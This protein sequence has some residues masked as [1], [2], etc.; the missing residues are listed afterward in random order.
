MSYSLLRRSC[1]LFGLLSCTLTSA[2]SQSFE[3]ALS[4]AD[5][6]EHA[7]DQQP[8]LFGEWGGERTKLMDEGVKFGLM[9]SSDS[10]W[11]IRSA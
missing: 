5:Q 8:H 10:L 1:F 7:A 6:S 2:W 3:D 11:N 4:G 9:Y